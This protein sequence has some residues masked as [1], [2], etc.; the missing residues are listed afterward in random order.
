MGHTRTPAARLARSTIDLVT[1]ALSFTGRVFGIGQIAVN[2][3][4]A[5]ALVPVTIVSEASPPGSRKWQ[6]KSMNPG[7]TIN[8][9]ASNVCIRSATIFPRVAQYRR[10]PHATIFSPSISTSITASTPLAGSIT[11]PFL[12]Q[13]HSRSKSVLL[14]R[15]VIFASRLGSAGQIK[16]QRHA[17]RNSVRDLFEHAGLRAV[18]DGGID[19]QSANHRPRMQHQR[20]GPSSASAPAFS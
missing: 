11:R 6:C 10:H 18:C 19:F 3:P 14:P 20:S 5:A 2:P 9:V 1:L 13:K 12:I 15:S 17:H 7:A 16:K 4:C 8:P